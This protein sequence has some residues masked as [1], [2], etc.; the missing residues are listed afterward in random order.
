MANATELDQLR[1]M[2]KHT[3]L[4]ISELVEEMNEGSFHSASEVYRLP[5]RTED[6]I[7]SDCES[8]TVE[9]VNHEQAIK[10]YFFHL[11]NVTVSP[12]QPGM[13]AKRLPGCMLLSHPDES[14]IRERIAV[15][16]GLK[17]DF[18]AFISA[19]AKNRNQRFDLVSSAI[20]MLSRKA[21]SRQIMLAPTD[22][23]FVAYTWVKPYS[24]SKAL[25]KKEWIDK[26]DGS[27]KQKSG[28]SDV[29]QW[30]ASIE[31]EKKALENYN[32]AEFFRM[33]RPVRVA[34]HMN[35]RY[36]RESDAKSHA[37][38][39]YVAHSPLLVINNVPKV[40]PLQCYA[41]PSRGGQN[42]APVIERLHLYPVT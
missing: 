38:T 23:F 19:H 42:N 28:I 9:A 10:A 3:M 31:I 8:V 35:V 6:D 18:D 16:N 30:Q 34:P 20:P 21:M 41:G 29:E 1:K 26:L 13:M 25:S 39:S 27:L 11:K 17:K 24:A 5:N 37:T 22:T 15:I 4:H 33:V 7:G 32:T 36:R 12:E 40:N 2:H 14:S